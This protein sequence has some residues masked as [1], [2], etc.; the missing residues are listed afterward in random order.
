MALAGVAL[1][2]GI[3]QVVAV[4][5]RRELVRFFPAA[6]GATLAALLA[7]LY[8]ILSAEF[9]WVSGELLDNVALPVVIAGLWWIFHN[10]M[11]AGRN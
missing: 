11:S 3:V 7:G 5:R 2:I 4:V 6:I 1:L 9:R 10:R 8:L